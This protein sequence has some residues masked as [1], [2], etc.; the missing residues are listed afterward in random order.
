MMHGA[1]PLTLKP[2]S[3][4]FDIHYSI[5][6]DTTD[7]GAKQTHSPSKET[8]QSDGERD[9]TRQ[10]ELTLWP[11]PQREK[12]TTPQ[13]EAPCNHVIP[14]DENQTAQ[15]HCHD[16]DSDASTHAGVES[17]IRDKLNAASDEIIK[18]L[19]ALVAASMLFML[20]R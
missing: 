4:G 16:A 11:K 15:L 9:Q 8:L 5:T 2:A 7:G 18:S 14:C 6:I 19:L 17:D 3:A 12:A 20:H 1:P 10:Q 13:N